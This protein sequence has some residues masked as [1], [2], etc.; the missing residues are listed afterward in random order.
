MLRSV[1][2]TRTEPGIE[3]VTPAEVAEFLRIDYDDHDTMIASYAKE[4]RRTLED[5]YLWKCCISQTCID[6]FDRLDELEL[7]FQPV[8]AITSI[9]YVDTAGDTQTLAATVYEL[10]KRR[11]VG[12]VRLKYGQVWPA[13]RSHEDV[14]TVTYTA[15]YGATS[16][17]V[18]EA[19]R[20][21]IIL[22][23][24]H[25]YDNPTDAPPTWVLSRISPYYDPRAV[26]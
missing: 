7:H 20:Q 16:S 11:G 4:A 2:A 21:S 9:T 19:I 26:G 6:R 12:Y 5:G 14:V 10:G 13:T 23:A 24:G 1:Y 18:P 25:L 8:S 22:Y 3:P 17:T 15:G